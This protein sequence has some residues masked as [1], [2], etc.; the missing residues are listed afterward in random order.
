MLIHLI[1]TKPFWCLELGGGSNIPDAAEAFV[2]FI[3]SAFS[4]S[5]ALRWIPWN[6]FKAD[7]KDSAKRSF[8]I[9]NC[10]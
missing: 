6:A 10:F 1:Q 3:S 5:Y 4:L 7:V 9:F 8:W 2:R